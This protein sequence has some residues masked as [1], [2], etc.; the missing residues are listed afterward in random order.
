MEDKDEPTMVLNLYHMTTAAEQSSMVLHQFGH[1]LGLDH[2]HQRSQFWNILEGK[3]S[4][5]SFIIGKEDMMRGDSG[6][7]VQADEEVFKPNQ[8]P[9]A[10]ELEDYDPDSIMHYW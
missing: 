8:T 2:E 3:D 9:P 7:C 1:A 6:K 10:G 5:S 4:E